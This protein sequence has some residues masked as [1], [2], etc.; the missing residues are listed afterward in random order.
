MKRFFDP[1]EVFGTRTTRV[2][3]KR[4]WRI[5][6][7]PPSMTIA[8]FRFFQHSFSGEKSEKSIFEKAICILFSREREAPSCFLIEFNNVS[9]N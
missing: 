2:I 1:P 8:T 4:V 6:I 7:V 9:F 3:T 5:F